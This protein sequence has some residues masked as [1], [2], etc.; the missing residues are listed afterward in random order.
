MQFLISP[1][2]IARFLG[3]VGVGLILASITG[4]I[5]KGFRG[6]GRFYHLIE[7]FNADFERSITSLYSVLILFCCSI[8]LAVIAFAKKKEGDRYTRHWQALSVIFLVLSVDEATSMHEKSMGPMQ[9]IANTSGFFYFAWVIPAIIIVLALLLIYLKFLMHLPRKI[10]HLFIAAGS[11]YI[12]GAI[13]MEMIGGKYADLYGQNN[14]GYSA[15][16]NVE[17]LF[18]IMGIVVFIYTL[19]SYMDFY[20]RKTD[21]RISFPNEQVQT[22]ESWHKETPLN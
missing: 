22:E 7:L 1:K 17:E 11:L 19:L 21:I 14:L 16:N 20:F 2:K 13:G 12:G 15:I 10:Q 4:Q 5:S 18:E 9:A 8:L 3:F 6:H